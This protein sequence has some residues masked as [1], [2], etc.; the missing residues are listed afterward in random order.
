MEKLA[1]SDKFE[2]KAL[3]ACLSHVKQE[4]NFN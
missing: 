2:H 3:V 4:A 1:G